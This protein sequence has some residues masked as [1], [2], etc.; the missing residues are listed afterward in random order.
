MA[1]IQNIYY[2]PAYVAGIAQALEI[3]DE[4]LGLPSEN[5]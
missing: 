4:S 3:W 5:S 1:V 2:V